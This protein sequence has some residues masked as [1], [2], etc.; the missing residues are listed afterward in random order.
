MPLASVRLPTH[1]NSSRSRS[2]VSA[3][4]K[5]SIGTAFGTTVNRS[6]GSPAARATR[7]ARLRLTDTSWRPGASSERYES[8]ADGSVVSSD[9]A[10]ELCSVTTSGTP[11]ASATAEAAAPSGSP[12]WAWTTSI[13]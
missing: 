10:V 7:P 6:I 3:S 9:S 12:V 2:S 8:S 1:S 11:S 13:R 4:A 5:R